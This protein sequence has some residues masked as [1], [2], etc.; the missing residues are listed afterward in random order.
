MFHHK[1]RKK[2]DV[3]TSCCS[4]AVEKKAN[5]YCENQGQHTTY[6]IRVKKLDLFFYQ[7]KCR[8]FQ[9][10]PPVRLNLILSLTAAVRKFVL[11]YHMIDG[12]WYI[13]P[14]H[15]LNVHKLC[16]QMSL[17][18]S[19]CMAQSNTVIFSRGNISQ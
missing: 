16:N 4:N 3:K 8:I 14:G 10:C 12:F 7:Q 18:H 13:S 9:S 5:T 11:I 19:I 2:N 1:V 17:F 15:L 6:E